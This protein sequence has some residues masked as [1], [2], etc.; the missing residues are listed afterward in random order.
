MSAEQPACG[1]TQLAVSLLLSSVTYS[2][3]DSWS[4]V[5]G[6]GWNVLGENPQRVTFREIALGSKLNLESSKSLCFLGASAFSSAKWRVGQDSCH[7][8]S[9]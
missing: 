2:R 5:P 1:D 8:V 6:Y 3:A 7:N 9:C 4:V